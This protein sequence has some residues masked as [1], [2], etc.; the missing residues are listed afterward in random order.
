MQAHT[1][2]KA[3]VT[4]INVYRMVIGRA[5]DRI[6]FCGLWIGIEPLPPMIKCDP[7]VAIFDVASGDCDNSDSMT[8]KF[9]MMIEVRERYDGCSHLM[10]G[11]ELINGMNE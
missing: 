6:S 8:V 7:L 1:L 5:V 11:S 3:P 2:P 4:S 9:M 10:N